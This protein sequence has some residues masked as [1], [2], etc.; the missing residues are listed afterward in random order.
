MYTR[1]DNTRN[2][3][4]AQSLPTSLPG[5]VGMVHGTSPDTHWPLYKS[6]GWRKFL[7][8]DLPDGMVVVPHS[9]T[10]LDDR[11]TVTEFYETITVDQHEADNAQRQAEAEAAEVERRNTP[12]V[13]D[14][15]FEMPALVLQSQTLGQGVGLVATDEGDLVTFTYHASPVPEAAVIRQR[16]A[17]AIA[18]HKAAKAASKAELDGLKTELAEAKGKLATVQADSAKARADIA[19]LKKGRA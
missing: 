4:P 17:D 2:I 5:P 16:I 11:D 19:E 6:A 8:F 15:P 12:M 3:I 14:Q 1:T 10:T 18:V 7:P 13:F 9:R